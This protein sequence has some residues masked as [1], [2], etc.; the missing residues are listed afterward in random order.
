MWLFSHHSNKK[1]F[2]TVDNGKSLLWEVTGKRLTKPSYFFGTMHLMCAEDIELSINLKAVIRGTT[3]VYF[4]VDITNASEIFAGILEQRERSQLTLKNI[5]SADD[6]NT[7]KD[8]FETHKSS[9]SFSN[10]ETQ[11]PLMITAG[12]YELLMPCEQK[13]GVELKIF[14]E[15]KMAQKPVYGL[16][17]IAFQA[18]VFD[19]IS[20]EDQARDLLRTIN[21]LENN[22]RLLYEMID[23]Y[24]QQDIE[25]LFS[26]STNDMSVTA[27][28]LDLL[29]FSRNDKWVEQFI[30]IA[31]EAST[32]F[33]VGA[34]HLGG[35]K[36]V[37]NLLRQQGYEVR[38]IQ[39]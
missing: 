33:A 28:Y 4:E 30:D 12:I 27:N 3:Q 23:V 21:N 32:L 6:Y 17:S 18:G 8:F 31:K 16:E 1:D 11:P 20:F 19:T 29:L 24:K 26:L 36:G 39:N 15:A 2:A 5:L 35:Q 9:L 22:R 7:I 37:L 10:L 13:N 34:G 25:K 14:E 38:P